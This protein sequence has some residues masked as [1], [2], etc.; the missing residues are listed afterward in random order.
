MSSSS[1]SA[2]K[3]NS[4]P[5]KKQQQHVTHQIP[6][7]KGPYNPRENKMTIP[8]SPYPRETRPPEKP[9]LW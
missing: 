1:T 6:E 3:P 9:S 8:K 5:P 7:I 2:A 4:S